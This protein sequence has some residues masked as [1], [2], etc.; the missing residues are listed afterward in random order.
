MNTVLLNLRFELIEKLCM[1]GGL[2]GATIFLRS[3]V[4]SGGVFRGIGASVAAGGSRRWPKPMVAVADCIN[5]VDA[6]I[7]RRIRGGQCRQGD[8]VLVGTR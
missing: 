4:V 5:V 2:F 3:P 8:Q 7:R 6:V 1:A